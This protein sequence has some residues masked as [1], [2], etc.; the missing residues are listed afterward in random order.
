[1]DA[2]PSVRPARRILCRVSCET[3]ESIPEIIG[4]LIWEE[5]KRMS[6]VKPWA[7]LC[8]DGR[9]VFYEGDDPEGFAEEMKTKFGIDL[10]GTKIDGLS[11]EENQALHCP[12]HLLDEIYGSGKY[13]MGS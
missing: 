13:R 8:P 5:A 7:E 4:R 10:A 1:M 12:A 6:W 3:G 9:T 2:Q 11:W